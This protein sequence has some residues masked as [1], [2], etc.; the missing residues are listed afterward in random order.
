MQ[1]QNIT[2][3]AKSNEQQL[4]N[5]NTQQRAETSSFY[6][7]LLITWCLLVHYKLSCESVKL[8]NLS[9]SC[10]TRLSNKHN[11]TIDDK[12]NCPFCCHINT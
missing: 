2:T 9:Y 8:I 1:R 6:I 10:E 5:K 4:R 12:E 7:K 3:I 11:N